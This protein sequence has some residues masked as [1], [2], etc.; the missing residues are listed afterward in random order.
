MIPKF[1]KLHGGG[2][3]DLATLTGDLSYESSFR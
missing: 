2:E 3:K 1:V